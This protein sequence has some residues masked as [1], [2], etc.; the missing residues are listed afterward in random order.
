MT[1]AT[2]QKKRTLGRAGLIGLYKE[3]P[4]GYLE[5]IHLNDF[6]F[7]GYGMRTNKGKRK[8]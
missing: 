3:A 7:N 1:D 6:S 4:S 8:P 5:T 2:K